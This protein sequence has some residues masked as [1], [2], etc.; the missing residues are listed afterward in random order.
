MR[1]EKDA[2]PGGQEKGGVRHAIRC[3]YANL[4]REEAD[5]FGLVLA[6]SGL[7][8]FQVQNGPAGWSL[9][10]AEPTY[11]PALRSIEQYCRE[12]PG[13]ARPMEAPEHPAVPRTTTAVWVALVLL[14]SFLAVGG[15][16]AFRSVAES[17][18]A[19]ASGIMNGQV[20]RSATALM[21]HATPA[22][23][24]GNIVGIA[25]F[26]TAVCGITGPGVGWL[27]ILLTGIIG[28][29]ANAFLIRSGHLSVGAS[30]AV[31]GALG[32][33]S[34][35]QFY[36]KMKIPDRRIKAWLPLAGGLALL[37]FLG[38]AAHT[39]LTAHLFGFAA[40]IITGLVYARYRH[41][42]P[43]ERV[44]VLCLSAAV[45]ILAGSWIW[46]YLWR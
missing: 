2:T 20:F 28:N 31:F 46:A 43:G 22:H 40:G 25:L 34:A 8:Y 4:T 45:C 10:V 21:L 18:G 35:H 33:L 16:E 23:L 37:G 30:T 13:T 27:L 5:A 1:Q 44:Q 29:L 14:S 26:G 6:S 39:D 24:A 12:N 17:C 7:T 15:G 36:R 42:P 32:I 9:W 11:R 41:E 19:S 3:L 38:T